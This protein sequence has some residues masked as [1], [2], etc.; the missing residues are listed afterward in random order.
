MSVS[1]E[2]RLPAFSPT[3]AEGVLARWRKAVGDQVNVGD[4]LAEIETDKI[5]VDYEAVDAGVLTRQ[6]VGEGTTVKVQDVIAVLEPGS[7]G[8]AP[9]PHAPFTAAPLASARLTDPQATAWLATSPPLTAP[10]RVIASPVARRLARELTVDL[11]RVRGSGPNGRIIKA[12]IVVARVQPQ[13]DVLSGQLSSSRRAIAARMQA[14]KQTIP[15]FYLSED[16][17]VDALITLKDDVA[18]CEGVRVGLNHFVLRAT[19]MASAAVPDFN[20]AYLDERLI[21]FTS[22]DVGT[23]IATPRG[24]VA[25]VLRDLSNKSVAMIAEE[26]RLLATRAASGNLRADDLRGGGITVSSLGMH[27][28]RA[29][30]AI[31]NPPQVAILAVGEA[32]SVPVVDDGVIV[33]G[34]VM[35]VT[36][37]ADHRIIDGLVA[38]LWMEHFKRILE[39]PLQLLL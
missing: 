9:L 35:S 10:P 39:R 17:R 30:T 12:D 16:I 11:S 25:P 20:V 38:S 21:A 15:H 23:A 32:R 4:V 14:S 34:M 26:S 24:L 18:R 31:I 29:F 6:L 19:A 8:F 22:V 33:V 13:D 5:T 1:I 36:L 28:V 27:H 7:D 2:V 37:S 3:M